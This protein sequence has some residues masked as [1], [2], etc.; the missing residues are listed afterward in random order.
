M[1]KFS[2]IA[3]LL[4]LAVPLTMAA[5]QKKKI[6]GGTTLEKVTSPVTTKNDEAKHKFIFCYKYAWDKKNEDPIEIY[7]I[8]DYYKEGN[9]FND[10]DIKVFTTRDLERATQRKEANRFLLGNVKG[11]E[12]KK[13]IEVVLADSPYAFRNEKE[14][15]KGVLL[16][17]MQICFNI[18]DS[19][20]APFIRKCK[21]KY[22]KMKDKYKE[23]MSSNPNITIVYDG[24]GNLLYADSE[25]KH[26]V[27]KKK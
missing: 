10:L 15:P 9:N 3:A 19:V 22:R 16:C 1:N 21:I 2:I 13:N 4:L 26:H 25:G 5:G 20:Y 7:A 18:K 17:K 27:R 23:R 14:Y 8:V 12:F 24:N 11:S 6:E